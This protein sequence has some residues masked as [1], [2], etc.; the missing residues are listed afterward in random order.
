MP[1]RSNSR[2]RT[3]KPR[4]SARAARTARTTRAASKTTRSRSGAKVSKN[5]SKTVTKKKYRSQKSSASRQRSSAVLHFLRHTTIWIVS[6]LILAYIGYVALGPR[7]LLSTWLVPESSQAEQ[8]VLLGNEDRPSSWLAVYIAPGSVDGFVAT[9]S[10]SEAE[11]EQLRHFPLDFRGES[12]EFDQESV[13]AANRVDLNLDDNPHELVHFNQAT[14]IPITAAYQI[15]L[16]NFEEVSE[17][18]MRQQITVLLRQSLQQGR[19][20]AAHLWL[21]TWYVLKN[22]PT[23]TRYTAA[24]YVRKLQTVRNT[25]AVSPSQNCQLAILNGTAVS[26]VSA[27]FSELMSQQQLPV[28]RVGQAEESVAISRLEIDPDSIEECAQ[29]IGLIRRFLP[30]SVEQVV[31]TETVEVF[32]APLVVYLG[33]DVVANDE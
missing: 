25:Y 33:T 10:L 16:D 13:L 31:T 30:L 4:R 19:W 24:E 23:I 7:I 8:V 11:R 26:G 18:E 12:L 27:N 3:S 6:L 22:N 21:R 20:Q 32:R 5:V 14:A 28:V 29:T 2:Q 17:V 9:L 1:V 15:E